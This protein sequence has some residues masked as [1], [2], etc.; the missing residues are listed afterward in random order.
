MMNSVGERTSPCGKQ[1]VITSTNMTHDSRKACNTI[2]KLSNDPTTSS[3]P[4]LVS[5]NQVAHHLLV[6]VRGHIPSPPRRPVL[7]QQ[8]KDIPP[9]YTLS[10]KKSRGK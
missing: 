3:P 2:R 10:V 6:N 7:P 5:A 4:C 8:Q 9:W 1:E